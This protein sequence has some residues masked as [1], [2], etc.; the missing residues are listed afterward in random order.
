MKQTTRAFLALLVAGGLIR[1]PL[2]HAQETTSSDKELSELSLEELLN[3][4]VTTVSK[5]AETSSDA[6]GIISVLTRDD[7][8]RFGGTNLRDILLRVPGLIGSTVYM[9]DRS[10]IAPRGEQVQASSGH[11]LLLLNGRPMR[12][13]QEG[14]IKSEMLQSFP[15]SVIER[16]EVIRGPGSVLYGSHAFSAVI[17]VIT[18]KAED[19]GVSASVFT[20]ASGSYGVQAKAS[21]DHGDLKVVAAGRY[22]EQED[23]KL[24]WSYPVPP[25]GVE[26]VPVTV[27]D[28]GPGAYAEISYRKLRVMASYAKW[29]TFYAI[30]DYAFVFPAYGTAHWEK[31]F[32]DAG[33]SAK[34]SD[35]WDMDFN[36]TYS[37]STF[38]TSSWPSTNRD[39]YEIV[40]EWTNYLH[41]SDKA[42]ITFGGLY[43]YMKGEEWGTGARDTP[44]TD[45]DQS[46]FA[47]YA[48]AD[49]RLAPPLKIIGG[50][51][52][53]K[54]ED[55]DVDLNPRAGL[56][57]E[58]AKR[59][60]L[61][62]LYS[63]AFRAPSLNELGIYHPAIRG[64][65]NLKPEK[66]NTFDVGISYSGDKAYLQASA[67]HSKMTNIIYQ[68]RSGR[69]EIP[70]YDNIGE[71]TI[72]GVEVEAKYYLTKQ[73]FVTASTLFQNSK[74]QDGNEDV[75]PIASFGLKTGLSYAS[76][77]GLTLSLFNVYQGKLDEKYD[78][79]LNESPGSYDL[80]NL[81][82]DLDLNRLLGISVGDRLGVF[83]QADNLLN[84]EIWLPNW[85]L[86]LG[87]SI[88]YLEGRKVYAGL[89]LGF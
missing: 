41:P 44:F 53:N 55:L 54:V 82:F 57:F 78:S 56:I 40:G 58:P 62:A 34:V 84:E 11:V 59:V 69:Y 3:I 7:L 32:A 48:Q 6:P 28:Q 13:V 36:L 22:F 18:E 23:W 73:V 45:A 86:T 72:K 21:V 85:G 19:T 67:F 20:N 25:A 60:T 29:E 30:P 9:T 42:R 4:E 5:R 61:K 24:N 17:N 46:S 10:M 71:V 1:P 35:T 26:T 74:D 33:Y 31:W 50:L 80:L 77:N 43:N 79:D 49:Y 76:D 81:Y 64:N 83:V 27:P 14:G 52:A 68:D 2:L 38:D 88:P 89:N 39:S 47:A 87:S 63:Q 37:R 75:T 51:Q 12:E 15:V 66:V 70:T 8:R 16:I 65:P